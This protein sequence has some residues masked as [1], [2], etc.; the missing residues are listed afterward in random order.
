MKCNMAI[1]ELN[2]LH[3]AYNSEK[4][5]I[6]GLSATFEQGKF[7]AIVGKSGA[8]KS[9]LLSL[10]AGLDVPDEG[11]VVFNG[12][13][14]KDIDREELRRSQIAVIYQ[15]FSLFPFLTVLEN[16]M[17]PMKLN[18]LNPNESLEMAKQLAGKVS[19]A[20]NLYDHYPSEISGGEQ[21]RVAIARS[22][23]M[24]RN[25]LLAD[26]PTGNLDSE[27]SDII[28]ETLQKLA[29]EDNKCIIVVTHDLFVM[30][31]ADV[32]YKLVDGKIFL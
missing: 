19:L 24:D 31:K 4:E 23:S 8:G 3:Y 30:E 2:D 1:L 32:V 12:K 10:L 16:I 11:S 17:Y 27:N 9:T 6:K 5:V 15:D 29:H 13:D 18:N 20:D 7:Y 28:I 26:E 21:Q 25:L 14:T 22:L